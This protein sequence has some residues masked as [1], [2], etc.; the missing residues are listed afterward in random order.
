MS[1]VLKSHGVEKLFS[2]PAT[3]VEPGRGA[4]R[5]FADWVGMGRGMAAGLPRNH[6]LV[7]LFGWDEN[8][9]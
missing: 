3:Q 5:L 6:G 9:F 1:R 8:D 4:F 2:S 7:I